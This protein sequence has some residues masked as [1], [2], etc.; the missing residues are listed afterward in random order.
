MQNLCIFHSQKKIRNTVQKKLQIYF[1]EQE[2]FDIFFQA[3]KMEHVITGY[4]KVLLISGE[5]E[6]KIGIQC[7]NYKDI[8]FVCRG[9]QKVNT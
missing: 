4:Y 6:R 5:K 3:T 8:F 1:G 7:N 9:G 2:N